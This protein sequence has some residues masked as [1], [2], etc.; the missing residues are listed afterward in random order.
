MPNPLL[1][2]PKPFKDQFRRDV[3]ERKE[4]RYCFILGAGA[5]V[6]SG[7]PSGKALAEQW[8]NE[9][10]ERQRPAPLRGQKPMTLAE[11]CAHPD[12]PAP[13]VDPKNPGASYPQLFQARYPEDDPEGQ[14]FIQESIRGSNK[15]RPNIPS[16][17]YAYLA[18]LLQRTDSRVVITTNFDHLA[19]DSLLL[20]TGTLPRIIGN[21]RVAA[22]A[23]LN[24]GQPLIAKIHGDVGFVTTNNP[25]GVAR[26]PVEWHSPLRE[27]LS[28][29]IPIFI[30]YDGN[31]GSLMDFLTTG[32][33]EN[34]S[35]LKGRSLFRS[36]IYWCYRAGDGRDWKT[37]IAENPRLKKLTEAH[38]VHF[39]PIG[40]F[41]LWMMELGEACD[42]GDP[43]QILRGNTEHRVKTLADQLS[44]ARAEQAAPAPDS[45]LEE[46][47]AETRGDIGKKLTEWDLVYKA[48][49]EKDPAK[50]EELYA[51]AVKLAP[52]N[53]AILGDYALFFKDTRKDF[54]RAQEFYERSLKADPNHAN[55]LHNYA[56]FLTTVRKDFDR[57]QEYY[58]WRS[59]PIP[60]TPSPSAT[61]RI[62]LRTS[63][64]STTGRRSITSGRSRPIPTTLPS[65]ATTRG[66]N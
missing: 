5:S 22:F 63:A 11:W 64:R 58:E 39:V 30:G 65:S 62:S 4:R 23:G 1:C 41:D 12:C 59:T 16:I 46:S 61:M 37:R 7:I 49:T 34:A 66:L 45:A 55:H 29:H 20:F 50:A 14:R 9:A 8:L 42:V 13:G 27:I 54:D 40:D 57:A 6:K 48:R 36:G 47:R 2:N 52:A 31:D 24:D 43:E 32:M 38:Q 10:Y 51:Q 17:G 35:G 28:V 44:K 56:L 26:L 15:N 53:T 3:N 33:F 25:G 60:T 21:E 19:A 18:L